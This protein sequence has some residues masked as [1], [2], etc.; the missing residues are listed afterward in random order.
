MISAKTRLIFSVGLSLV[1]LTIP[2]AC[3]SEPTVTPTVEVTTPLS[4]TVMSSSVIVSTSIP[5]TPSPRF[6]VPDPS[7]QTGP[8][9]SFENFANGWIPQA[10]YSTMACTQVS[11]AT[12]I[13]KD[14]QYSLKLQMH[15]IGNNEQNNRGEAWVDMRNY[16]PSTAQNPFVSLDLNN[17]TI[18]MWV[19]A[20]TGAIGDNNK[21]NGLQIFVKDIHWHG[22]YSTWTNVVENEWVQLSFTVSTAAIENGYIEP[23][24][25]PSQIIA[26]GLKA[27]AGGGSTAVYQGPIYIDA[28]DW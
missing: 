17:R 28:V 3:A 7:L 13:V 1:L 9:Y 2:V 18:T 10:Y 15:L 14:G 27:G 20:P 19:Y 4:P 26:V 16:A 22:S 24:F 5:S 8:M 12:E 6:L 25:D 23:G 21:P 11:N